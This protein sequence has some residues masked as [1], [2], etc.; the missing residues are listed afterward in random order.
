MH[1]YYA[2][3]TDTRAALGIGF[4]AVETVV[5]PAGREGGAPELSLLRV[6]RSPPHSRSRPLAAR[7]RVHHR[8]ASARA[9][10][11]FSAAAL[12]LP[13]MRAG[14]D[15]RDRAAAAPVP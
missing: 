8:R 5:G 1:G 2:R 12:F 6:C 11:P 13:A 4:S 10:G 7:Q 3:Q 15:R 9:R 14:A